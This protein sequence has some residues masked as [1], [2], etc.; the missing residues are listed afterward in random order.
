MK[1]NALCA[2]MMLALVA[3]QANAQQVIQQYIEDSAVQGDID[4]SP[5][6]VCGE[7]DAKWIRVGFD[8]LVL[9]G[10]DSLELV[11]SDGGSLVLKG[12]LWAGRSFYVRALPGNCVTITPDFDSP[13]S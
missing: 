7:S 3:T 8:S 11:G 5:T 10:S 12:N 2:A 6:Q 1:S 4:G 13:D 9:K